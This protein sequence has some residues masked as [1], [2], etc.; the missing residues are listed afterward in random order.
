MTTEEV[1][2]AAGQ[3]IKDYCSARQLDWEKVMASDGL[4]LT[5][6]VPCNI[7][8]WRIGGPVDTTPGEPCAECGRPAAVPTIWDHLVSDATS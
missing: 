7:R 5:R 2:R 8:C 1:D 6:L 4:T 3:W